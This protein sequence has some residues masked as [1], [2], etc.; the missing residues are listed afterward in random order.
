M[1][2]ITNS[3][4]NCA[5]KTSKV[6]GPIRCHKCQLMCRDAAHYLDHKCEPKPSPDCSAFPSLASGGSR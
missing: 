3:E 1:T 2:I 6:K 4:L 5:A